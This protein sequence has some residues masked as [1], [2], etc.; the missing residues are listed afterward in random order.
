MVQ[1]GPAR[2]RV[3]AVVV[4]AAPDRGLPGWE[5]LARMRRLH[6]IPAPLPRRSAMTGPVLRPE[7]LLLL[8]AMELGLLAGALWR[9]LADPPRSPQAGRQ[10]S[11]W[12]GVKHH[13]RPHC[14]AVRA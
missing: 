5:P 3:A 1:L 11:C 14:A 10:R 9:P 6:L 7:K 12:P 4:P 8:P 13:G 2:L